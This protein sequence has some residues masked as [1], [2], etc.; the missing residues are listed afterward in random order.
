MAWQGLPAA[1]VHGDHITS[2][3]STDKQIG[4]GCGKALILSNHKQIRIRPTIPI[5][6]RPRAKQPNLIRPLLQLGLVLKQLR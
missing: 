5:P 6:P 2:Q 3:T 1:A 4:P